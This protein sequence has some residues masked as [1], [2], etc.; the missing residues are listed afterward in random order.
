MC[1]QLL[2][3]IQLRVALGA[4]SHRGQV[5]TPALGANV[6]YVAVALGAD[7]LAHHGALPAPEEFGEALVMVRLLR[8]KTK[9]VGS[10]PAGDPLCRVLRVA[11][12]RVINDQGFHLL[13]PFLLCTHIVSTMKSLSCIIPSITLPASQKEGAPYNAGLLRYR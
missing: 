10:D 6:L 9:N 3:S 5:F 2:R 7:D 1:L 8:H 13:I 4:D 12:Q 11:F